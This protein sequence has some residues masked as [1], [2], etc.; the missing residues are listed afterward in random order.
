MKVSL[1]T[2][3]QLIDFELPPTDELIGRINQQLGG[4]EEVIDLGAKYKDAVIVKVVKCEKHPN[5]DKL[6]VCEIDAGTGENIQVVCGAPNVRAD[7]LTVWLPPGST[8]PSTFDQAEPFVLE[9]RELRGVVSNGMLAAGDELAINNDHEGIIEVNPDEQHSD[10]VEIKPGASFAEAYGLNDTIIDIENKMFTHRPDCFGQL[11]VAREIAGIFGKPFHTKSNTE[12]TAKAPVDSNAMKLSVSNELPTLAPRFMAQMIEGVT[13]GPSSL[14]DQILL[15]RLGM[16]PINNIVDVTNIAMLMTGQPLHAYDYDKV[17]ALS[18]GDEAEIIIRHPKKG[19]R[20]KLLNG[21][22][23]EPRAEAIMIATS[24]KLIG[25]GGVMGGSEAEVDETTK[26][27]ILECANFDMYSIR[28]TSMEHGLF[29]DA[30]TRFTKGQS[31]LQC[32]EV[33][34]LAINSI[35]G[36]EPGGEPIGKTTDVNN[37]KAEELYPPVNVTPAFIN[38][39]LGLTLTAGEITKILENVEFEVKL[40]DDNLTVTAPYWRTDIELPEDI[41]EEVG[42]LYGFGKLPRELPQRSAKPTPKN[43]RRDIKQ[44]IRSSLAA[45]GANEVLTYSFV[46][47]NLMKKAEQDSTQAFQLSNALSPD[48]QYYRLSVLPSLLAKVHANVK[49]GYDQFTLFELGKGHNKKYHAA[50]DDGLPAELEFIDLVYTSKQPGDGAAFY[51]IRRQ[52]AALLADLHLGEPVIKPAALDLDFPVT[53]PFDLSRSALVETADGTFLGMIGELKSS[54][55]KNFKLPA[56]TAAATLDLNG[57]VTASQQLQPAA[58]YQAL[59]KYPSTTQDICFQV[60]KDV[61]YSQLAT[62]V[63]TALESSQSDCRWQLKPLDIYHKQ[64]SQ[65]KNVTFRVQFVSDERTLQAETVNT[66]LDAVAQHVHAELAATR[67]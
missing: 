15:L 36:E 22:E 56:Y 23:I 16:K 20:I 17:K 61:P 27:I 8:V 38:A 49:A 29:T 62:S 10:G 51:H 37:V 6:S 19:E 53:A 1:N 5:A 60:A 3:K 7:M 26:N 32:P 12:F 55:V 24:K 40:D 41:V 33:M 35:V 28:R 21:Q 11:G 50:D 31:P 2:I 59:S 4:V 63:Q 67:V 9:A 57:F 65:T 44:R 13:V 46:H 18:V 47:E 58:R 64:G 30:V 43:Y 25:I 45:A 39:R 14:A 42:R 48:L 34:A 54:V 66:L 52:L